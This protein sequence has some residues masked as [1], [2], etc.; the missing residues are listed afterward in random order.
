MIEAGNLRAVEVSKCA[1]KIFALLENGEPAESRLKALETDLLKEPLVIAHRPPPLLVVVILVEGIAPCPEAAAHEVFATND[2]FGERLCCHLPV[3][4]HS[5]SSP[6]TREAAEVI[7]CFTLGRKSRFRSTV[8]QLLVLGALLASASSAQATYSLLAVD[9]DKGELGGFA[10][11][12]IAAELSLSEVVRL[13]GTH[14]IAAQ[15]YFFEEGRDVL[16]MQLA[17]G[18]SPSGA[19]EAA[20]AP[21]SDPPGALS[22][23]SYRQYAALDLRGTAAQHSGTDLSA[24]AGHISGTVGGITYVIQGNFLT[25][26]GVLDQLEEGFTKSDAGIRE[27]AISA[28]ETLADSGGG[29][30][31]CS[32]RSGDAGYFAWGASDAL[33]SQVFPSLE[34]EL[35][36]P[37]QEVA[38]ALAAEIGAN[39]PV[40]GAVPAPPTARSTGPTGCTWIRARTR[41]G[42]ALSW[43]F[44]L[45]FGLILLRRLLTRSRARESV[46]LAAL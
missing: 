8:H 6:F 32:P 20:L 31:R 16:A 10:I 41:A 1:S 12:C 14:I 25:E 17:G 11:S 34:I 28:L 18:A 19:I 5:S 35:V 15:G 36:E 9:R 27:R 3:T 24:F 39:I 23:P 40:D 33:E 46:S 7:E 45:G 22:G 4:F 42:A 21:S 43:F 13:T 29:D 26:R 37:S 44:F 30:S 38:R 2:A